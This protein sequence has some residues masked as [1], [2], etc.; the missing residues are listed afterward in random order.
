MVSRREGICLEEYDML[1]DAN[2]KQM[3]MA[4]AADLEMVKRQC[5]DQIEETKEMGRHCHVVEEEL[6]VEARK[7]HLSKI[8]KNVAKIA[9]QGCNQA[10]EG[11][12]KYALKAV[13]EVCA[14]SPADQKCC[15][16]CHAM[17]HKY[18]KQYEEKSQ[19]RNAS[20]CKAASG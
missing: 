2:K 18:F 16:Q 10:Y 9:K 6:Q 17:W 19:I 3:T 13:V 8:A 20:H 7:V 12:K 15:L 4:L 11:G 14:M 1:T 5:D